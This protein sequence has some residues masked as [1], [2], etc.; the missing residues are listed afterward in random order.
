MQNKLD[1]I[2]SNM[3]QNAS[4]LKFVSTMGHDAQYIRGRG[5]RQF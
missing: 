3:G 5:Q 4:R 2:P 1:T